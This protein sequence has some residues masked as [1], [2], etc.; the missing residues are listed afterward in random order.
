MHVVKLCKALEDGIPTFCL[1]FSVIGT[2]AYKLPKFCDKLLKPTTT[3]EY[4]IKDSF[5]FVKD[6]GEFDPNLTMACFDV[7]SC[8][9]NI[10]LTEIIV[11]C[12][13]LSIF[14][15]NRYACLQVAKVL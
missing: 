8:F 1:F 15:C 11:L 12:V 3:K 2:P 5:S 10:P 9:T 14:F 13:Y 7:K 4:I 6:F